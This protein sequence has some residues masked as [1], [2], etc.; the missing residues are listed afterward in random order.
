MIS[1]TL[2]IK[3]WGR[4]PIIFST[5]LELSKFSPSMD[6]WT[7]CSL[8]KHFKRIKKHPS[9]ISQNIIFI[10]FKIVDFPKWNIWRRRAPTN[11][12][13]PFK[14]CLKILDT[15]SISTRKQEWNFGSM[16]PISTRKHEVEFCNL[17]SIKSPDDQCLEFTHRSNT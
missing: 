12:E 17:G 10:C 7:L 11:D 1:F 16:R 9:I 14:Q 15:R 8:P 2:L 4:I 13:D 5:I 6:P 3:A